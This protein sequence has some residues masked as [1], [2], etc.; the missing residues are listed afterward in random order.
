[1]LKF[2]SF[3]SSSALCPITASIFLLA[4]A[5]VL[6]LCELKLDA[7]LESGLAAGFGGAGL[8]LDACAAKIAAS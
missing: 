8:P 7:G 6:G 5:V 4:S 3:G 1:M 2:H